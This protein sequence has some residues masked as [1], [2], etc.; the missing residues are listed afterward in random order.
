M[1]RSTHSPPPNVFFRYEI[2]N[3]KDYYFPG[4]FDAPHPQRMGFCPDITQLPKYDTRNPHFIY[5]GIQF[6]KG[7]ARNPCKVYHA[8]GWEDEMLWYRIV[9]C[10]GVKLYVKHSEGCSHVVPV[11]EKTKCPT[12]PN[13]Q[14]CQSEQ[15]PVEFV[16]LWPEDEMD[17]RRWLSGISRAESFQP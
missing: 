14:L 7:I 1:S 15:C 8:S 2:T 13:E 12:H 3:N 11:R 16:Y 10:G 5:A 9:P 6:S 17:K 4:V